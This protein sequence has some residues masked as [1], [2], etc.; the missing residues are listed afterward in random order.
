MLRKVLV[1]MLAA[2]LLVSSAA[3]ALA[4]TKRVKVGD[5]WFVRSSGVPTV[6]V[7]EGDK[8]TWVWRG[9][10]LHNVTVKRGPDK[11]RS[12][13]KTSGKFSKRVGATGSYTI[14]CTVHGQSDQSMK[15]VVR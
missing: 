12:P 4:A 7:N 10:S 2:G 3:P 5:N 6:T 1:S 13:S 8:V 11:F 14:V 9:D 15:L